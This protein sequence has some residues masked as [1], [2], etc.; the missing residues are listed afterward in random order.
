M[1]IQECPTRPTPLRTSNL[2][3]QQAAAPNSINKFL[4]TRQ[5][6]PPI[7]R[8]SPLSLMV[9][10]QTHLPSLHRHLHL[11]LLPCHRRLPLRLLDQ[12]VTTY[13]TRANTLPNEW[14]TY[15]AHVYALGCDADAP[16]LPYQSNS[17]TQARTLN[18]TLAAIWTRISIS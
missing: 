12:A 5:Y 17:A 2:P 9:Q 10:H 3:P 7:H 6:K 14:T 15:M 11:V 18:P 13:V 1:T 16:G 4:H 8:P